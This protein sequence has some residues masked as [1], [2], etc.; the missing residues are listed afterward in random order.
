MSGSVQLHGI[1]SVFP[2]SYSHVGSDCASA[3][4]YVV[5]TTYTPRATV[6]VDNVVSV[7]LTAVVDMP[8]SVRET[9]WSAT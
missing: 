9:R 1:P 3:C 8:L 5:G 7:N 4:G 6:R 2:S